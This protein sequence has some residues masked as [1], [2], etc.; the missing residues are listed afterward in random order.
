MANFQRL[1]AGYDQI[2]G[3]YLERFEVSAVRQ[4]WLHR[5]I[6]RLPARARVLDLGC[7]AGIPVARELV[8]LG[9]CVVGVDGSAEQ[10]AR[11]CHN[12]PGATFIQADVCEVQFDDASFD[13]IGAFYSIN[14]V[15]AAEQDAL[16][17]KLG[18]WLKPG[19]T[20]VVSLG[21]GPAGDWSGEWLGA[22]MFFGKSDDAG[23]L[24]Q[25]GNAGRIVQLSEVQRQDNED[26]E[27]LW[28]VAARAPNPRP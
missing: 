28:I 8:T 3:A 10:I 26:A 6:E 12:V 15:P 17:G 16:F 20:L 5:L 2:A 4:K 23:S 7:G 21:T 25:L 18:R 14:H 24:R 27:F 1:V 11:A 22:P 13:A 19:G 9:H